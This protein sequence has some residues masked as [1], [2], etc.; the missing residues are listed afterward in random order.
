MAP[1]HEPTGQVGYERLRPAALRLA[2]GA[3]EGSDDRDPHR[4]IILKAR[5]R[6]GL[7]PS[8]S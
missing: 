7:V 8:T 1:P 2:D 5:S 6:G 4:A 3:D